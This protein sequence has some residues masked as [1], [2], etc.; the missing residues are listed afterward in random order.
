MDMPGIDVVDFAVVS[1]VIDFAPLSD[2]RSRLS[3]GLPLTAL[4]TA[5]MLS[6]FFD[7]RDLSESGLLP[8]RRSS[9]FTNW[10]SEALTDVNAL[11]LS[12]LAVPE[13]IAEMS[14]L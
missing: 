4:R 9:T 8:A 5:S 12:A 10:T 1:V 7:T 3:A 2:A 6:S 11:I 14:E 13:L